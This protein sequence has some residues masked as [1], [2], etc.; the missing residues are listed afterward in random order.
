MGV[1]GAHAPIVAIAFSSHAREPRWGSSCQSPG[2]VLS[3][4]KKR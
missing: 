3:V 1:T 2:A 4:A